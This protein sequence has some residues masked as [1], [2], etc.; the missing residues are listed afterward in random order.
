MADP[1]D[2]PIKRLIAEIHRRSLWQVLGIYL[3][4]GWVAYQ[5]VQSLTEGLGLPEW[6]PALAVVLLIIGLPIVLATAFIQQ[7]G[8]AH[9]TPPVSVTTMDELYPVPAERSVPSRLLTWKKAILGGVGAFALWGVLA[10]GWVLLGGRPGGSTGPSPTSIDQ[11]VA[12]LPFVN[13]SGNPDNEYF[14]DG[15]TE[16]LLNALAQLP[17]VRV[18]ART[19]SFAFKGQNIPIQDIA[20]SLGVANVLEGSVRRDGERVLITAQLVEAGSGFHIW[21]DTYERELEDIFAI[22]RE[23]ATAIAGQLQIALSGEQQTQ[24]VAEA[25]ESTE[26]Y[27][28]YLRGRYLLEQ[29]TEESLLNAITEF[30][31]AIDLDPDYA[32][33]YAGLADS[34]V[35]GASF[36][37]LP[38]YR[39]SIDLGL[40]ASRRAKEL[41]PALGMALPSRGFGLWNLGEWDEAELAF[42][43][44]IRLSPQYAPAHQWYALLLLTTGRVDEGVIEAERAVELDPVYRQAHRNLTWALEAAGRIED[45]IQRSREMLELAPDWPIGWDNY[46]LL[47][48]GNGYHEEGLEAGLESVRLLGG[49][50]DL[51]REMFQAVIRYAETG[52][53]QTISELPDWWYAQGLAWLYANL[54]QPDR[55]LDLI[56]TELQAGQVGL[57]ALS[58]ATGSF[59]LLGDD[60]RYQALLEEAG[61]TW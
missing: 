45:A 49:D 6:F 52:E 31:Q 27:E 58:H 1:S 13:M 44:A 54:G 26:A 47:L 55:A 7:G 32:E 14:S 20:E 25:T 51:A 35:L 61:I 60:P 21:S 43:E 15:I 41:D 56:E 36:G 30:Q 29:R 17:G 19:S 5:V 50:V 28:E 39:G 46:A 11:S 48:L 10:A 59:K 4:G 40:T 16:E 23:I 33:A 22:Q 9:A 53:P 18:P 3:V 57:T 38:D 34:Y 12:V 37:W 8:P 2:N 42:Q 24:L